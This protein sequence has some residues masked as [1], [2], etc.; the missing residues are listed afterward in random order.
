MTGREELLQSIRPEM[1]L[2]RAFFLKVYGLE[3]SFPGFAGQAISALKEAGCSRAGQYYN[4]IVSDYER[5]RD[6]E[7]R[8]VARTYRERCEVE[9]QRLLKEA[10]RGSRWKQEDLQRMSDAD[11]IALSANLIGGT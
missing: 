5:K 11:L 9:W 2:N 4:A 6:A 8:S 10:E 1:R 3:I 7:L